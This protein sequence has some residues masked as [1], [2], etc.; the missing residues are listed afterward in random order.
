M[1]L[2]HSPQIVTRNLLLNLDF[3]NVQKCYNGSEN[4]L[5]YSE[6]FDNAAWAYTSYGTLA[7]AQAN[8]ATAPDGNTTADLITFAPDGT[9]QSRRSQL[10]VGLTA[11][12]YTASVYVKKGTLSS[13]SWLF[14]NKSSALSRS[15][16]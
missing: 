9:G 13:I 11:G 7:T 4:L 1:G 14:N 3:G 10:Y 15:N 8:M 5:T 12:T 2:G 16:I 6:Q